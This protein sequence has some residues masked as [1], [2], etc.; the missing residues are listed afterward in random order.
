MG[1]E[2]CVFCPGNCASVITWEDEGFI[3]GTLWELIG[4]HNLDKAP[5]LV[6]QDTHVRSAIRLA[7]LCSAGGPRSRWL[8]PV[9]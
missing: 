8:Q 3:A 6:Q 1:L 9:R 5:V 4:G 7:R 2:I